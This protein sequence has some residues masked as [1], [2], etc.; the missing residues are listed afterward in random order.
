MNKSISHSTVILFILVYV[1]LLGG[2][3]QFLTGFSYTVSTAVAVTALLLIYGLHAARKLKL[4]YDKLVLSVILLIFYI[5][6]T[7]FIN[8]TS[9]IKIFLYCFFVIVPLSV[10]LTI[11]FLISP[12]LQLIILKY[13]FPLV[14]I[15]QLPFLLIQNFGYS[16]LIKFQNS[17]QSIDPIDFNFGTFFLKDDHGLGFFILCFISFLWLDERG[18]TIKHRSLLTIYCSVSVF[19][20]N[21]TISHL[22]LALFLLFLV[23][24]KL[25]PKTWAYL[26]TACSFFLVLSFLLSSE[27]IQNTTEKAYEALDYQRSLRF[28]EKGSATRQQT[29][30]VLINE[31]LKWIGEGPYTY[32]DILTGSFYQAPNFSQWLWLYFDI[33]LIGLFLFSLFFKRFTYLSQTKAKFHYILLGLLLVYSMFTIVTNSLSFMFTYFLFYHTPPKKELYPYPQQHLKLPSV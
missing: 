18:K 22:L 11:K 13:F 2:S 8:E 20:T 29:L 3:L 21:S 4:H 15:L 27:S 33:G 30:I 23:F 5:H 1:Y 26:F 10:Y 24:S 16:F 14:A 17:N 28:Y 9:Y 32:F 7:G 12:K 25:R 6:L 19:L 31:E